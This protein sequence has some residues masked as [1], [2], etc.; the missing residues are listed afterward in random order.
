MRSV[1]AV[2]TLV[3]A[4]G[5]GLSQDFSVWTMELVAPL[6]DDGQLSF[7]PLAGRFEDPGNDRFLPDANVVVA[8]SVEDDDIYTFSQAGLGF[9]GQAGLT[10]AM[11]GLF[12]GAMVFDLG[13][14]GTAYDDVGAVPFTVG[15]EGGTRTLLDG[16]R[17]GDDEI[18][19]RYTYAPTCTT[20][21]LAAGGD[22]TCE[23][24]VMTW[25]FAGS[26]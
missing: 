22:C 7:C 26:Q 15:S 4:S 14:L 11:S 21:V 10:P 13:P 3:V 20:L 5:C 18:E 2:L 9:P 25:R 6:G 8:F 17:R 19:L 12:G 16:N 23:P 24:T 1:A